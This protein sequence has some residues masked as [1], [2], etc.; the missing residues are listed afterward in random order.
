MIDLDKKSIKEI[1]V[2][3]QIHLIG[4]D[5]DVIGK[6]TRNDDLGLSIH[7]TNN[8]IIGLPAKNFFT[9]Y[10]FELL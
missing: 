9:K 4:K 5:I 10:S 1:P 2:G 8:T 6:V 3:A 7:S